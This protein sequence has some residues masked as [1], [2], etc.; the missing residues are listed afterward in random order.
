MDVSNNIRLIDTHAHLNDPKFDDDIDE[1]IARANLAGVAGMVVCGYDLESSRR[2]VEL[3]D[4]YDCITATVGIHPHDA[5]NFDP[6]VYDKIKDMASSEKVVAIGEIGLDFHYDF[7]PHEAQI[8]AFDTQILLADKLGL[9]IVVHSREAFEETMQVMKPRVADIKGC[10]FHCFSGNVGAAETVLEMGWMIGVDGPVTFSKT[11]K[12]R[13]VMEMCPLDM[14][15]VETDCPY[16][17]PVPMRGNRNEPA[18]VRYIAEEV[19]GIK[20]ISLKDLAATTT[21]NAARLFGK[22]VERIT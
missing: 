6:E 4:K 12:L 18:F 9:P 22:A 5:K 19:A 3:A 7:S 20:N 2:A 17:A 8:S 1:V 13:R 21:R 14:L 16:M 15:V 10:V 11:G